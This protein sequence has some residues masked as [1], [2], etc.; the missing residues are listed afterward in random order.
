[1]GT[2]IDRDH[3]DAREQPSPRFSIIVCVV[4]KSP[5]YSMAPESNCVMTYVTPAAACPQIET[6]FLSKQ[7]DHDFP[8]SLRLIAAGFD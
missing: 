4:G 8:L 7:R 1:M 5:N 2:R 3:L 6:V